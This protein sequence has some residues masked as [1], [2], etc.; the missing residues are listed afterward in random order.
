MNHEAVR[1]FVGVVCKYGIPDVI[2]GIIVLV[3]VWKAFG[4]WWAVGAILFCLISYIYTTVWIYNDGYEAGI[5]AGI[6]M[7]RDI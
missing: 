2:I 7:E 6:R 3:S 1:R 4:P 5:D